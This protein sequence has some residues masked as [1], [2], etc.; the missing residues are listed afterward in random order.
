VRSLAAGADGTWFVGELCDLRVR[1]GW[2]S[3]INNRT[4]LAE[5]FTFDPLIG[6]AGGYQFTFNTTASTKR[7]IY[8]SPLDCA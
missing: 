5:N 2:E 1:P 6:G 3:K 4:T 8:F 7:T